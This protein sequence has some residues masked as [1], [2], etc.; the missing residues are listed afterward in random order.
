M[1]RSE[2]SQVKS[3]RLKFVDF[4]EVVGPVWDSSHDFNHPNKNIVQIIAGDIVCL[5]YPLSGDV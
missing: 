5:L 4:S 3:S 1:L 2:V